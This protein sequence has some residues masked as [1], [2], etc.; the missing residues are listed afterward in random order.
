[1]ADLI[2]LSGPSV[3]PAAGGAPQQL[4]IFLHGVG[5]D[6]NDLI[7]LA[8]YFQ[9]A[10]PHAR[11]ISPNAPYAF[12]M[13]PYGYQWFSLQDFTEE[14]RLLGAERAAP[15]LNAFI[16][17]ELARDGLADE[18]L[19]LIGFSQGA[20]MSLHVGLRRAR[21]MAGIVSYSGLLVGLDKLKA[22]MRST[23]P[24]L[25]THG[26][27]DPVLPF[28]FLAEAEAGLKSLGLTVEAHPRPGLPHGI[29]G[30]CI[31]LGQDFL[32]RA[33]AAAGV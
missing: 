4:V 7:G 25:L 32:T 29:D 1:M 21:A 17:A 8:P 13:A 19:A 5:A 26:T 22:E 30:E 14:A 11:F 2:S 9:K 6:G 23:P 33:F 28:A 3:P 31:E 15:V 20:M 27:D 24:V 18:N 12:D 10:L 16:D